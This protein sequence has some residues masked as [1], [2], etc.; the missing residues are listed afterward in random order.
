MLRD[1]R[2]KAGKSQRALAPVLGLHYTVLHRCETGDRRI[3]PVEFA[4]WCVACGVDPG[5]AIR[6]VVG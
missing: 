3:D 1:M 2:T 6:R 4:R 5:E